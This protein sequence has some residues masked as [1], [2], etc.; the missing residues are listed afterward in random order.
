MELRFLHKNECFEL[1]R[2]IR[3]GVIR[4]AGKKEQSVTIS[5]LHPNTKDQAVIRYLAA[6]GKVSTAD[7]VILDT[8]PGDRSR[9]HKQPVTLAINY[10]FLSWGVTGLRLRQYEYFLHQSK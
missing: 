5:G 7:R 1:K 3:T 2:G 9:D 10:L 8:T 6:H 4:P